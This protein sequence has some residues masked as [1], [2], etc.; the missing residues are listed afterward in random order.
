MQPPLH[1]QGSPLADAVD[2]LASAAAAAVRRFG[3]DQPVPCPLI[4]KLAG[5][6][7]PCT[8]DRLTDRLATGRPRPPTGASMTIPATP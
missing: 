7:L 3:P 1:P 5:G 8:P 6:M 4:A 2:A